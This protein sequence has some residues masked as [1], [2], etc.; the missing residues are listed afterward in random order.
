MM[1]WLWLLVLFLIAACGVTVKDKGSDVNVSGVMLIYTD[2][3]PPS[4]SNWD[5]DSLACD[6]QAREAVPG[7]IRM[8]GRR[9]LLAEQCLMS[10]GYVRR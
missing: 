8:P 9:Q 3:I 5:K 7:L 1:C 2:W 4:D 10:K 6:Y